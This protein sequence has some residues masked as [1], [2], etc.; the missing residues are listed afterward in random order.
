MLERAVVGE[1]N[2]MCSEM[3][4]QGNGNGSHLDSSMYASR[5]FCAIRTHRSARKSS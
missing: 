2:T 3:K 1:D 4:K 5:T